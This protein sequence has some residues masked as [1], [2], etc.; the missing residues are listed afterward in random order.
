M[1]EDPAPTRVRLDDGRDLHF[2]EY[3]VRERS[4]AN[5][6]G[7]DLTAARAARAGPGV[8]DA[9]ARAELVIVCPSNPIVS[10]GPIL[11][12][13]GVRDA[14]VSRGVPVVAISPII[15]GAPVKGPAD[16]LLRAA[17]CEVS[18]AG[19]ASLYRDWVGGYVLDA[20]DAEALPAIE[21]MGIRGVAT[22]TLMKD[23]VVATELART[24]VGLGLELR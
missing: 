17:G 1:T 9:I 16:H 13:A 23:L 18:A 3:L 20:L 19:V 2:E 5:V 24:A 7:V 22:Q 10:I 6:A 21:S 11:E 8:L 12:V 14:I 15:A 4:P